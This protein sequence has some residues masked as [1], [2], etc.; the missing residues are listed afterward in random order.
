V[1]INKTIQKTT[2]IFKH[3]IK[4]DEPT[5]G[6]HVLEDADDHTSDE[7]RVPEDVLQRGKIISI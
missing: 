6:D 2:T 4:E 3:C 5:I 7:G 1:K